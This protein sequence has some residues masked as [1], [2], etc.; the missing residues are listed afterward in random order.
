MLNWRNPG[1]EYLSGNDVYNFST[2]NPTGL[3]ANANW[4]P[5]DLAHLQ[6]VNWQRP[7]TSQMGSPEQIQNYL[8][9]EATM[10][11]TFGLF[12]N[13]NGLGGGPGMSGNN[14]APWAEGAN[15]ASG[16]S[17]GFSL[18][19]GNTPTG[20]AASTA[21]S[22]AGKTGATAFWKGLMGNQRLITGVVSAVGT[23]YGQAQQKKEAQKMHDWQ[24]SQ[25]AARRQYEQD[26]I[27]SI[28]NSPMARLTPNLMMLVAQIFGNR[29]QK[30][31]IQGADPNSWIAAMFPGMQQGGMQSSQMP[32]SGQ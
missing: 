20:T 3:G 16:S 15:S 11:E 17:Q 29:L 8:N 26:R 19:L 25:L 14:G 1:M 10:R 6:S 30:R 21:T 2:D 27:N 18:G 24:N 9:N 22:A 7:D 31:G 5:A 23:M 4:T 28:R 12:G 32:G 13:S